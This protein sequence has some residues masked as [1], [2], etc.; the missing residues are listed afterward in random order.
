MAVCLR[1]KR[2]TISIGWALAL[3]L[4][5]GIF[6]SC[7]REQ[8]VGDRYTT[9]EYKQTYCADPWGYGT[10]DSITLVKLVHYFDSLQLYVA[11]TNIQFTSAP[12]VCSACT[13]KTGKTLYL[14]TF[15]NLASR[16]AAYGFQ[17]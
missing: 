17:P 12:D 16:F 9:L 3:M 10:T 11:G 1:M 8:V 2:T 4:G 14:S 7:K 6:F 15:E 5:V 13:C